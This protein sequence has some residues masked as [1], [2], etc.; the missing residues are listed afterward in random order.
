MNLVWA[1][2]LIAWFLKASTLRFGGLRL[3][4]TAVPFF[5]GLILGQ[6][7]IGCVWTLIGMAFKIPYYSFWGAWHLLF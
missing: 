5:L 3:Y 7:P 4:K 6:M 1:P 2:I